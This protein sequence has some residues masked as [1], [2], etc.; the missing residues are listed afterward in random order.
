MALSSSTYD[1]HTSV[2][3]SDRYMRSQ[4]TT[5]TNPSFGTLKLLQKQATGDGVSGE[6][7]APHAVSA[8][9]DQPR[10]GVS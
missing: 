9:T 1:S 10:D 7:Q 5:R 8:S 4:S 6:P 3:S 2:T